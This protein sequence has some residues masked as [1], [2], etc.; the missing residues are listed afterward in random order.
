MAVGTALPT[1]I[2]RT[3]LVGPVGLIETVVGFSEACGPSGFTTA[4][5]A[6]LPA[7]LLTLVK[8]TVAIIDEPTGMFREFVLATILKSG[9]AP[10]ETVTVVV[11]DD[12]PMDPVIVIVYEPVGV[13]VVVKIPS[14]ELADPPGETKTLGLSE[15]TRPLLE[16]A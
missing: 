16:T 6:T 4:E 8:V 3:E 2:V 9:I 15:T 13:L 11:R 14:V 10:T 12:V 5:R 1:L 7:K